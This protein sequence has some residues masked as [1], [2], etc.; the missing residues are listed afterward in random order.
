MFRIAISLPFHML[1]V[2]KKPFKTEDA[3]RRYIRR[4][5]K[6]FP[7]FMVCTRDFVASWKGNTFQFPAHWRR[8]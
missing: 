8:R 7:A 3:A 6:N 1:L 5:Y 4:H 2:H